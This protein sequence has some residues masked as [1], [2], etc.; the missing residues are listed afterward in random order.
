MHRI[1]ATRR[2]NDTHIT[3]VVYIHL[4]RIDLLVR[5]R[6]KPT[7]DLEDESE[8]RTHAVAAE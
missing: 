5:H 2:Q 7:E 1:R 4:D 6:L 3:P 8:D